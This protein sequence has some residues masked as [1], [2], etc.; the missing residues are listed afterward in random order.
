MAVLIMI[1]K[2]AWDKPF[3]QVKDDESVPY[4]S[5]KLK[6]NFLVA[7]HVEDTLIHIF[8][9]SL[10]STNIAVKFPSVLVMFKRASKKLPA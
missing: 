9:C 6:L 7:L 4:S 5:I 1:C 3:T 8:N 10:H 2:S